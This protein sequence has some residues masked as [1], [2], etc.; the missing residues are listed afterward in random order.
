MCKKLL[1]PRTPRCDVVV[2]GG[3]TPGEVAFETEVNVYHRT[4]ILKGPRIPP[5]VVSLELRGPR[6]KDNNCRGQPVLER[7]HTGRSILFVGARHFLEEAHRFLAAAY[8]F[9]VAPYI[10]REAYCLRPLPF[11]VNTPLVPSKNYVILSTKCAG[12][13]HFVQ[14]MPASVLQHTVSALSLR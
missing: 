7:L 12:S 13:R 2:P 5:H 3:I 4:S 9:S 10:N 6:N 14:K 1:V 11:T 8:T